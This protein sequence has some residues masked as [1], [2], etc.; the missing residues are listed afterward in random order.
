MSNDNKRL[1]KTIIISGLSAVISYLINFFLTSYISENVGIDAYG[2]VAIAKTAVSY[3]QI[4]TVALTTFIV[5]YI[6][7]S[8]HRGEIEKANSYYSSSV[9]ACV[10]L[11]GIIYLFAIII[12][13]KLEFILKIPAG[14]TEAVKALF[15]LVF[16][17]FV[18]TTVTTPLNAGCFIKNRLDLS[19]ILK[20]I[21]YLVDAAVLI[22]VF[23]FWVP[24]IWVVGLGSVVSSF[25]LAAGL[26]GMKRRLV[27]E[28]TFKKRLVSFRRV[29]EM[30][31]NGIW[32][33]VNSL[34]NVLNSG[35]DLIVS[36]LMLTG[37]ETG[38]VAAVK[39]IG[40]MFSML[41]QI[42]NQPFQPKMLR[43]YS[44]G[45][46]DDFVSELGKSMKICGF[47]SNV[48]FAGFVALGWTY[49]KLWLPSQDTDVLYLL[50][51]IAVFGSIAE[52]I[53][54]PMYFVNT[55]TLKKMIPC[56][57]TLGS[58]FIN[59]VS[60]YILL[61]YTDIGVYAIV[62]TTAVI[63]SCVNLIFN[64]IYCAHCLKIN[65]W[66]LY[67]TII[68]HIISVVL[69]IIVFKTLTCIYTPSNWITLILMGCV[70]V[71]VGM[72]IHTL[73]MTN[74]NEKKRILNKLKLS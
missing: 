18:I 30:M 3:A 32:Q 70:M 8:Y 61:K 11:S 27:T 47:F 72:V 22:I 9:M 37:T 53:A 23:K 68:R 28:L 52:G 19:G 62:L 21:S 65:P 2:F 41:Y 66:R 67:K 39:T 42:V 74:G 26:W 56:F 34:G 10:T 31:S 35:L 50:T 15:L 5:R 60:M 7:I 33:S 58:G 12:I 17:N 6:S 44:N 4:I 24:S 55:L 63:M 57:V 71:L 69:Q 43:V 36:N 48:A 45:S 13:T 54:Q 51:V 64:P 25:V 29:W 1:V 40:T 59:T 73:V 49:Y 16:L 14:L 46:T 38:Q 20:I